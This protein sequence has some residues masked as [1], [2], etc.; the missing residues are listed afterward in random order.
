M[1]HSLGIAPPMAIVASDEIA[2]VL[3]PLMPELARKGVGKL[4]CWQD[5]AHLPVNAR[6]GITV[7]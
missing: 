3:S 7:S 4:Y 1:A 6:Q 2:G 5:V